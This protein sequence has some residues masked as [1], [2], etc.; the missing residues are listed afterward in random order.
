MRNFFIGVCFILVASLVLGTWMF[1]R[2]ADKAYEEDI[3]LSFVDVPEDAWFFPYVAKACDRNWIEGRS[4]TIFDPHSPVTRGEFAM[5]IYRYLGSPDVA[6]LDNPFTDLEDQACK[7]SV[8]Y[9]KKLEILDGHTDT[10][11]V[12]SESITREQLVA[13]LYRLGGYRVDEELSP[14]GK[15]TDRESINP[16]ALDAVDW[17]IHNGFFSGITDT[18]LEPQL[19]TTRAEAATILCLYGEA[20]GYKTETNNANRSVTLT[21]W[22]AGVEDSTAALTMK[23]LLNRF[24][25][26]NPGISIEYVPIPTKDD[27]YTKIQNALEQGKGPDVLLVSAPYEMLLADQGWLLPLDTLLTGSVIRDIHPALL[28]DCS[29]NREGN[30]ALQGKLVSA[31]LFSTPRALLLNRS[32]FDH[33]GVSYPN[34]DFTYDTLLSDAK[35]LTGSKD[36]KV[37]YGFGTRSSSP[38]LYLGMVW[39]T[40]GR[41]IDPT[42][43]LAST[44]NSR[45][46]KATEAYLQLYTAKITPDHSVSM[47]YNSQLGMFANGNV[48]M[49]DASLNAASLIQNKSEWGENLAVYPFLDNAQSA[50]LCVGEVAVISQSTENI[51]DS[52]RLINF[53]M[54]PDIQI[55][56]AKGVGYLPGV[57]SALEETEIKTD[58]YLSP[59]VAGI[60]DT[61]SL[62]D[63]GYAVYCLI[64][65]ELQK[66]LRGEL[67]V[68][69]YCVGLEQK[70]NALLQSS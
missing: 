15:Y 55:I 58:A 39:N 41:I 13:V 22:Q 49:I 17:A 47:D 35:S 50:C 25:K 26:N 48:A 12:P 51:V 69:D 32:I 2:N 16:W 59:Y 65:D 10:L 56:Y 54:E 38:C 21:V 43:G 3:S 33:F 11:F 68:Q 7:D 29:Y 67:S 66:V 28:M 44:N 36:G 34:N 42:T 57:M 52:A 1:I 31:P 45:W 19:P 5:M 70:I 9:L 23:K 46:E 18:M 37:I 62:G 8:I 4:L 30:E 24:E 6:G 27:P 20:T 60:E 40:G 53:L 61:A 64:R 63:Q 14:S